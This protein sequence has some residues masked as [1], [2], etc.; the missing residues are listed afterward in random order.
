MEAEK[1]YRNRNLILVNV[2]FMATLDASVVNVA[3]PVMTHVP[4]YK[5]GIAGSINALVRNLGYGLWGIDVCHAVI[6][7]HEQQA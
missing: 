2:V 1:V 4:K 6:Q 3:L 7:S 5:L